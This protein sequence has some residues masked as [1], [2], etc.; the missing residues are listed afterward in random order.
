MTREESKSVQ[1]IYLLALVLSLA[2]LIRQS[3]VIVSIFIL[4]YGAWRYKKAVGWGAVVCFLAFV[5]FV[6]NPSQ[7]WHTAYV[8]IGAYPNDASIELDDES[9]YRMFKN[10]TSIQINTTPPDGNYYD[11]S[12]RSQYYSV[13]KERVIGYLQENPIQLIRNAALN[14]FQ[15]FSVG[16]PVGHLSL[17]YVSACIGLV[18]LATL[19]AQRMFVMVALIF[20]GVVGFSAYYPPIPAY[21][22]GNY[23]LLSIALINIIEQGGNSSVA[24]ALVRY[25]KERRHRL[26]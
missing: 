17:A 1:D 10:V 9:G 18:F 13:L 20:A 16:Y 5:M 8:G 19:I 25:L 7:P 6:K 4:S 23:L 14:T 12:I 22:F 11:E 21:M 3:T 15:G 26:P 24:V 2:F